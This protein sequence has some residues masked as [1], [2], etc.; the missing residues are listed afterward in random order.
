[1]Q[2]AANGDL[3]RCFG[4][5]WNPT[6]TAVIVCGIVL[7]M[8]FI[9]SR[10]IVHRDLKPSNILLD[11]KWHALICDFGRSKSGLAEGLSTPYQGTWEYAAPEQLEVGIV[12][13]KRVDVYSFGLVLYS[14]L[15]GVSAFHKDHPRVPPA[16]PKG[17]GP[18]M[19]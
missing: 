11:E 17:S 3:S 1:M 19:E 6:P 10:G 7:G 16:V 12:Y 5:R 13:D 18:V 9:H 4:Q 2:L 8:R 14:L 15:S